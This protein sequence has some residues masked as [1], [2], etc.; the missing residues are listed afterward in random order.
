MSILRP[1]HS[2]NPFNPISVPGLD[3][4]MGQLYFAQNFPGVPQRDTVTRTVEDF[5]TGYTIQVGP[6]ARRLALAISI[7]EAGR[8]EPVTIRRVGIKPVRFPLRT[9][10]TRRRRS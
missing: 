5:G 10:L 1:D 2:R 7:W 8:R 6:C 3:A 9:P 4:S